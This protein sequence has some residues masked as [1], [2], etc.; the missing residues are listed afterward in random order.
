VD[1]GN[2]YQLLQDMDGSPP[3]GRCRRVRQCPPPSFEGDIDGRAPGGA[4]SVGP[5]MSTTK[6]E[7]DVDGRPPG[8]TVSGSDSVHHQG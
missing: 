1:T 7:E 2:G 4:L 3:G 8:G 6:V 5:I